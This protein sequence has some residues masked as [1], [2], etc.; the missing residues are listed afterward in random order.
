MSAMTLN[1]LERLA[2][3]G[4]EVCGNSEGISRHSHGIFLVARCHPARGVTV[5]YTAGRLILRCLQCSKLIA[6]IAVAED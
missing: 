3:W 4:C 1:S 5:F 2:E 6:E